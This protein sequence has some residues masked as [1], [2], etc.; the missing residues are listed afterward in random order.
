M[1]TSPTRAYCCCLPPPIF[2]GFSLIKKAEQ[3]TIRGKMA[4]IEKTNLQPEEIKSISKVEE[5]EL[6]RNIQGDSMHLEP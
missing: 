1:N 6:W 2:D 5:C 3:E 4:V